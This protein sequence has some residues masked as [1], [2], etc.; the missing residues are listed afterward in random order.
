MHAIVVGDVE[1]R[2]FGRLNRVMVGWNYP[3]RLVEEKTWRRALGVSKMSSTKAIFWWIVS[4]CMLPLGL[5]TKT[6]EIWVLNIVVVF[7]YDTGLRDAVSAPTNGV[8]PAS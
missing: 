3:A 6:G 1:R 2:S 7:V 4:A 8:V 5:E